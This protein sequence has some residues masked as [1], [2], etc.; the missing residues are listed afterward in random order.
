[1]TMDPTNNSILTSDDSD[2]ELDWEEVEVPPAEHL[3][4]TL[5][6]KAT[7]AKASTK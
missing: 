5:Q 6:P 3:E 2:D 1:M 4:I 7:S